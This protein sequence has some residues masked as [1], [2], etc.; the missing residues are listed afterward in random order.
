MARSAPAN[1]YHVLR[2]GFEPKVGVE[3]SNGPDVI[4]GG[5]G[6]SGHE[7]QGLFGDVTQ[8]VFNGEQRRQYGDGRLGLAVDCVVD[9]LF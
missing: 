2:G 5:I 3:G 9:P 4:D 6:E 7:I 1:L 8:F